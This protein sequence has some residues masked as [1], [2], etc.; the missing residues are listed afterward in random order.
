MS[1]GVEGSVRDNIWAILR[2]FRSD[3]PP[4]VLIDCL[5]HAAHLLD[6]QSVVERLRWR[7][8]VLRVGALRC[9]PVACRSN[10]P[11]RR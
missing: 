2:E 7:E 10:F 3:L 4:V 8:E 1:H 6:V 11:A 9:K 5:R